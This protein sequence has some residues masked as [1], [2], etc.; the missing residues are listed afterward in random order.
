MPTVGGQKPACIEEQVAFR[1][2]K[3]KL[4]DAEEKIEIVRNWA[5]RIRQEIDEY[6]GRMM[7]LRLC[8]ECDVPRMIA[9]LD[10]LLS[11]LEAY[12]ESAVPCEIPVPGFCGSES[13]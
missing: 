10:R 7:K 2:A 3:L 13:S 5:N 9:L 6:R 12:V 4:R 11:S 1:A 8:L